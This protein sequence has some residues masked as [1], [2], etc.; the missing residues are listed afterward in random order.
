MQGLVHIYTGD[1]KGKTTAAVGLG[2]RASGRGLKV[3]MIQFLKGVETGE[4]EALKKL[5]PGFTIH[6]G[7]ITGKFMWNMNEEELKEL[8]AAQEDMFKLALE[9]SAGGSCDLII[10]DEIMAAVNTGM[11]PIQ[12]VV[13]L[14]RNK[15]RSLEIVLTGRDAPKELVELADYVSEIN[16]VKHPF[17]KGIN[18]RKGIEF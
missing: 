16:M 7:Q 5:A 13:R 4:V 15:P 6:R 11:V 10:L 14:V 1:G 9:A 8:K 12:D 18:A 17:E 3:L 2:V